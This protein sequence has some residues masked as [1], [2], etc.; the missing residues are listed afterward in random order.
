MFTYRDSGG[1]YLDKGM[2]N[3][4]GGEYLLFLGPVS[5]KENAPAAAKVAMEA[6]Y[7]CGQSKLWNSVSV[8]EQHK[9]SKLSQR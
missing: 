7:S 5:H 9:L 1:F 8:S 2:A 4:L 3:D 6:N